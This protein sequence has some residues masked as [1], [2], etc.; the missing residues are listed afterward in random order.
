VVDD[1]LTRSLSDQGVVI[2]W[3]PAPQPMKKLLMIGGP[4]VLIL[5]LFVYFL[6]KAQGTTQNALS[7]RKSTARLVGDEGG[8]TFADVGGCEEA[9]EQLRD[10]ID[11]LKHPERWTRSGVRLP[12]GVLLEG[13]PGCGKTL[14]ARAVAGESDA[15]FYLVSASEFVE[16]FVGVGAARVRDTFETASKHAPAVIFIDEIDAVGRRRG[17]GIGAANDEREQTLNQIL[18]C[19]DGFEAPDRVVMIA[20]TNRP[21]VLDP[22]LLRPG[23][24]DRRVEIGMLSSDQRRQVLEIHTR[25][26]QLADDVCLDRLAEESENMSGADL[27]CWVNETGL[28]AVRRLRTGED[29]VASLRLEDFHSVR[30]AREDSS[31]RFDCVDALLVES[32]T[33][34]AHPTGRARVRLPLME[35][36]VVEGELVWAD[37]M[38]VKLRSEGAEE[39]VLVPKH[40]IKTIEALDGTQWATDVAPDPFVG[41]TPDL[42]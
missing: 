17:S 8:A 15:H 23:R 32:T 39:T 18:V 36:A 10:V 33:Q 42:A 28:L 16:M 9:K 20:A 37:A 34:L 40:Q 25:G 2:A 7:M 4:I 6:K 13:P 3:G 22:A 30:D 19:L 27:E 12:R 14:L 29:G 26:M 41:K 21:D 5:A 35:G 1:E 38:L 11:F 31:R 24:F